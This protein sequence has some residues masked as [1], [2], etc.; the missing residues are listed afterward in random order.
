MKMGFKDV[1]FTLLLIYAIH[2]YI[3]SSE[4]SAN[5]T[6]HEQQLQIATPTPTQTPAPKSTPRSS[7]SGTNDIC[8]RKACIQ[9]AYHILENMDESIDPCD[10]F[11]DFACGNF[12]KNHI[13]PDE[14]LVVD[15]FS[16]IADRVREQL[17]VVLTASSATNESRTF[18]LANKLYSSCMNK[19]IIEEKGIA[20]LQN[21]LNEFGG[22]PAVLGKE[23]NGDHW[24]WVNAT[25]AFRKRGLPSDI[26][27]N[28]AVDVNYR[29]STTR[30][31]DVTMI[32][33]VYSKYSISQMV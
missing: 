28:F 31:I 20:P 5:I 30:I 15:V 16:T 17:R 29:N 12:I 6:Y 23:W 33:Y 32:A 22:W 8:M 11:Y 21:L 13:V 2:P 26:I 4:I 7:T 10:N 24:D 9:S 19:D 27:F 1:I 3:V 25:K 14:K 18:A